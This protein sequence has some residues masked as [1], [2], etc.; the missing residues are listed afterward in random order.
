[1]MVKIISGKK[2]KHRGTHLLVLSMSQVKSEC[3]MNDF[4]TVLER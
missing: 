1:M 3:T 2:E 4:S